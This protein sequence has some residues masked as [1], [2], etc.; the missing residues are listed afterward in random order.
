[1]VTDSVDVIRNCLFSLR[2]NSLVDDLSILR[3]VQ[4]WE[5][6]AHM[7]VRIEIWNIPK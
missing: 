3:R 7:T 6:I 2:N 1:M 4:F 5:F